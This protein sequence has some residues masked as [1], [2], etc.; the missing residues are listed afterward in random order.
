M[1]WVARQSDATA[2]AVQGDVGWST[3][4]AREA[5]SKLGFKGRLV[6]MNRERW[7]RRVFEYL[8]A[9]CLRTRWTRRIHRLEQKY[10][11]SRE[12]VEANSVTSWTREVR[13]RVCGAEE[14]EWRRGCSE[15]SSLALYRA[16]KTAIAPS[17]LYDNSLG[18][19]LLFEARAGALRTLTRQKR[20]DNSLENVLCRAC[21]CEEE[22]VEHVVLHC[23]RLGPGKEDTGTEGNTP[24][25]VALGFEEGGSVNMSAVARTK[26]RLERWKS[27]T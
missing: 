12:P 15:K 7:A 4:E 20:L 16:H 13:Q 27:S 2:P 8:A 26:R 6:Y 19:T 23:D 5:S 9:T 18:S 1:R 17:R 24:L 11:L 3:F 10:G 25:H 22:T 21:G 14:E